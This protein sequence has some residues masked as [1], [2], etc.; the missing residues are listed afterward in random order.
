MKLVDAFL[1]Y[2]TYLL[3]AFTYL[4][5]AVVIVFSFNSSRT[6]LTFQGFTLDNYINLIS[7]TRVWIAWYNSVWIAIVVMVISLICGFLMAYAVV[8]YS[9]RGKDIIDIFALI[10][11]IIPEI[12]EAL[13]LLLT[14]VMLKIPLSPL[15]IIIGHLVWDI[16]YVYVVLKS[17]LAMYKKEYEEAA[18]TM[19]ADELQTFTKVTIPILMPSIL[20]AGLIAFLMSYDDF[21]KTYFTK[22]AGFEILPVY[23]FTQAARRGYSLTLNALASLVTIVAL[24]FAYIRIKLMGGE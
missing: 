3:M 15:T 17:A 22:P 9:F 19:G 14:F 2:F 5:I 8:R 18:W 16:G 20:S 1:K 23:I 24:I 13:T 10:P 6:S 12:V 7:D 11:I 21:I 4:P